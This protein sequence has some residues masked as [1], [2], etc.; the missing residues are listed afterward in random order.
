[1][2]KLGEEIKMSCRRLPNTICP[3]ISKYMGDPPKD[4]CK[5]CTMYA[6]VEKSK[7]LPKVLQGQE[8]LL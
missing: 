5:L 4:K 6:P 1:M 3:M 2:D 7:S 8:K